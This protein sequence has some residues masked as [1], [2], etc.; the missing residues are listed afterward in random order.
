[1]EA[2]SSVNNLGERICAVMLDITHWWQYFWVTVTTANTEL[3][4]GPEE[5]EKCNKVLYKKHFLSDWRE[6]GIQ[7][8][9]IMNFRYFLWDIM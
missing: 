9:V 8:D 7:E 1:M 2:I 5:G 3:G 6:E 4:V